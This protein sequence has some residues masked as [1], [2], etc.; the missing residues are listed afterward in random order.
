MFGTYSPD[1]CDRFTFVCTP[2][3]AFASCS[4][5][6]A[7]WLK[8][9]SLRP[10]TSVTSP[11]FLPDAVEVVGDVVDPLPLFAPLLPQPA[12]RRTT[13]S[14]AGSASG[15]VIAAFRLWF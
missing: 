10:P 15:L 1:D 12:T 8:P 2:S 9:L 13:R 6:Y 11:I 4:P 5:T 3:F 7:R 14:T